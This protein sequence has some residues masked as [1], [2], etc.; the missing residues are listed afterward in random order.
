[1]ATFGEIVYMVLDEIKS[2]GGDSS[3]QEEHVIFLAKH[4]RN[5]LLQQKIL[6]EGIYSISPSNSQTICTE[7]EVTSSIP[8]IDY[9]N[10]SYLKSKHKI[11]DTMNNSNVLVFP[12]NFFNTKIVYVTLERFRFVGHNKYMTNIIYCA[13][14]PNDYLYLKSNNPQFLYLKEIKI[15]G[16]FEDSEEAAKL[17]CEGVGEETTCD[18]MDKTFP[19]D[20][21]LI[22]Q[23]IQLIVKELQGASIRPQDNINNANDDLADIATFIRTNTKSALAKEMTE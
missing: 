15:K 3:I 12:V 11:P 23:V 8:N 14:G 5:M 18:I 21:D 7:L 20:S 13:K 19:I 6:K 10:E 4:Y 1:M 22:P 17:E 2:L 9:C 16:V